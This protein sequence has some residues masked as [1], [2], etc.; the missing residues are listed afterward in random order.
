M[1]QRNI[2][3]F[4]QPIRREQCHRHRISTLEHTTW[5]EIMLLHRGGMGPDRTPPPPLSSGLVVPDRIEWHGNQME[6]AL[7]LGQAPSSFAQRALTWDGP[8]RQDIS[9]ADPL[10]LA[11]PQRRRRRGTQSLTKEGS[12]CPRKQWAKSWPE[13]SSCVPLCKPVGDD[14]QCVRPFPVCGC[15]C[16]RG[17]KGRV[18]P[19]GLLQKGAFGGGGALVAT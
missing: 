18:S 5:E 15:L 12:R 3:L 17:S 2:R 11:V 16:V 9:A 6:R 19:P 14:V 8:V 10:P 7:Q 4:L 13:T 1:L